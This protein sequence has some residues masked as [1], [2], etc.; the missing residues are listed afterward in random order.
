MNVASMRHGRRGKRCEL[1]IQSLHQMGRYSNL[2]G[3]HENKV[4]V[5]ILRTWNLQNVG[6]VEK[7]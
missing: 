7:R 4:D 2:K 6:R 5:R 3:E 1:H